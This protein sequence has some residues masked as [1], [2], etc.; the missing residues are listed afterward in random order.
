MKIQEAVKSNYF[1]LRP[2]GQMWS[3]LFTLQSGPTLCHLLDS[4]FPSAMY[5]KTARYQIW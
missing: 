3:C 5:S 4:I 1:H 2:R